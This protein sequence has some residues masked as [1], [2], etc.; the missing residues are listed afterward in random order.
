[1]L[2]PHLCTYFIWNIMS[3]SHAVRPGFCID[4]CWCSSARRPIWRRS[5]SSSRTAA[6]ASSAWRVA[7]PST[8]MWTNCQRV[9]LKS[10]PSCE[11]LIIS[12]ILWKV[13]LLWCC[14]VKVLSKGK[15]MTEKVWEYY[16]DYLFTLLCKVA[17]H[18]SYFNIDKQ[19]NSDTKCVI[20]I[21]NCVTISTNDFKC[22]SSSLCS[23]LR[24][25]NPLSIS[26]WQVN[27]EISL[28]LS[29]EGKVILMQPYK[30]YGICNK[31]LS[32]IFLNALQLLPALSLRN[33]KFI[34][35]LLKVFSVFSS[36]LDHSASKVVSMSATDKLT[37]WQVLGYQ[38]ALLSH[39]IE[40]I[41]VQSILIGKS[42]SQIMLL[43]LRISKFFL[44]GNL[45][46]GH[47]AQIQC[48]LFH[49]LS[50]LAIIS[51]LRELP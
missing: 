50:M 22:S 35:F 12:F 27:N 42:T 21:W 1:M 41:Y 15:V 8:F 40:P 14:D 44:L 47:P 33:Y 13:S 6:A 26:A 36:A 3:H 39:F 48:T 37:Q 18:I 31:T 11:C 4:T 51:V 9:P 24:R 7:S 38:G 5:R 34:C 10:L 16:W 2:V 23:I 20:Y 19:Y 30:Q 45:K 43:R 46:A 32:F 17:L 28:H 29:V 49:N 25:L